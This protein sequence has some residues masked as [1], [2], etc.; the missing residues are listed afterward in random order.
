MSGDLHVPPV[1]SAVDQRE[2][3]VLAHARNWAHDSTACP[4][5]MTYLNQIRTSSSFVRRV[6]ATEL[7]PALEASLRALFRARRPA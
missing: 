5:C 3:L 2:R 4:W 1:W 6:N 7:P